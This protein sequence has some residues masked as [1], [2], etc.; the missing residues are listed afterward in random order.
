MSE[1]RCQGCQGLQ[2][3][4]R[5]LESDPYLIKGQ[6]CLNFDPGVTPDYNFHQCPDCGGVRRFCDNCGRDHHE[7]GWWGHYEKLADN[8]YNKL[9]RIASA[10]GIPDAG[11][12]CRLILQIMK[13][14]K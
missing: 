7:G 9:A 11:D 14:T 13:E 5:E 12:A 1:Q 2:D 10:C 4:I 8:A 3:R 6:P